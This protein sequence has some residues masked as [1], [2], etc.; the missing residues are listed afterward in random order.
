MTATSP[1]GEGK[2]DYRS[3]AERRQLTVM[4]CDL[5]GSTA[6]SGQLDPE[7]L[8]EVTRE[9]HSA[10]AEVIE[11]HAGRIA[12][13]QGD[14]LLVYF[15]YP[16]SH[17]DDAQ[18]AVR[19]GLEIVA[20]LNSLGES[21]RKALQVRIAVHTGLAVVGQLGG[22][23]NP[24]PMAISGETPN[25]A[26]RLQNIAEPGRVVVS[27]ATY[28]LI[29]GFFVCRSLG[30]PALKGV[31][32]PIEAFEVLE[33]TGINTRFERAAASG[34][35]PL[36][37]REKEV[38]LLIRH[39]EESTRSGGQVVMLNGEPGI[40]KSRLLRVL[41]ERTGGEWISEFE[42]RCSPY[43]QNSALY[44]AIDFLQTGLQFQLEDDPEGKFALLER[45]LEQ[46]GFTLT[47]SVPLFA[48]LLS[49][50]PNV[51][52][53]ALTMTPHRQKQRT[54]EAIV[55]F[56]LHAA[57]RRPTRF[58]VE[59]LHWAD[60]S[61][62]ELI[63]LVIEQ[64]PRA[65]LF[66]ALAFRPEFVPPWP[67]QPHITNITLGRLSPRETEVMVRSVAG[68]E[69]LPVGV[70]NEIATKTEGVPLFVEELTRMLLESELL[71][72][73]KS[74]RELTNASSSSGIPSTLY[75]SL[76][77]RLDR[78]GTAKEV[79]QLAATT[80]REFSYELLR[81][82]SPLEETRLSGALNRLVDAE[83]LE[84]FSS[85][86]RLS[87]RFRHALI[88]DAAYDS[89][90]R[91]E[92][93]QY[94]RRIAQVLLERFA[95][96]VE[97]QPELLANHFTEAGLLEEA[98]PYWQRAGQRALER[99]ANK[100]AIR[101]LTSGL[102]LVGRLPD[103][104]AR[105]QQELSF[106][107]AL[108]TASV[109]TKGFAAQ[110]V[111]RI[112]ERAR[113]LCHQAGEAPQLFP[114]LWGL[115]LFYTS[116]GQH[117]TARELADQCLRL[118]QRAGDTGLLV[119]SHHIAGVGLI[120]L[121]DFVPALEHLQRA[122]SIYDPR[123]H[124][125]HA[126]IYGH[127]PAA[128]GTIHESW[129]LWFL[130]Y[131]QQALKSYGAGMAM[132]QKLGHPYTSATAAVFGAWLHQFCRDPKTVEE[133]ASV[134]LSLSTE[135]DFPF[136]RPWAMMLRGW[137][138]TE[139]GELLQGIAA[140]RAGLN[141]YQVIGAEVL[142][143]AFLSLIADA[144]GKAGQVEKAFG[145]LDEAQALAD[146]CHEQ[147]W[148]AELYR[149]RGE[150]ILKRLD[151]QNLHQ[152]YEHEAG[153]WFE[154]AIAIAQEQKAKSL[155]LRATRSLCRLWMRQSK[156][157]EARNILLEVFTSFTE[158]FDTPDLQQAKELLDR[159]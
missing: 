140:M 47:D 110:E 62:L 42:I 38:E 28:R 1:L 79:A 146:K 4:F 35:T 20:A 138:L 56:L 151:F 84:E 87:Y 5:V 40:G 22:E 55:A 114:V 97:A 125:S 143:P 155:E 159:L 71:S 94:H 85:P 8:N 106:Q 142:R 75:D 104:P 93:R 33:P 44:P 126:Y 90:L 59:D 39:W 109:A 46:W 88:R 150:L 50:P 70:M 14:G 86:P 19:A 117:L 145:A 108:G 51:R 127:D 157:S 76:M 15:G 107:I 36:V 41:K 66:V 68:G 99:S 2:D 129:A 61:T 152:E 128:V 100:E 116:R 16:I 6:P 74:G 141:E 122:I 23:T 12:Q 101:H 105:F 98:I 13:F 92:R 17:E 130:G 43:T 132:A 52:Y 48:A 7:E 63:E 111:E 118:A 32:A 69:H 83:L 135:H 95:D 156:R 18:R 25:I 148:Q 136:Y 133:L 134:A 102:Q 27:A 24:N 77:A 112:Y 65:R 34:L 3:R 26:S 131:P 31:F 103:G 73:Q 11:R 91:S 81:A 144:H 21:L 10:C 158:G 82:I 37:G 154:R 149:L 147:W 49:L 30:T 96:I 45:K 60:P 137:V 54:L 120:A 64:V 119:E 80:G 123:Q 29:Q 53:P 153:G 115:W 67:A 57:E 58:I 72:K 113:Q 139:R 78:L 9:Y 121:G 124:G 89:L